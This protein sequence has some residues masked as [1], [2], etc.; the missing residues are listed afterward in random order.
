M[1]AQ[2]PIGLW[3]PALA[4]RSMPSGMPLTGSFEP[5]AATLPEDA[6][7]RFVTP[8]TI[9]FDLLAAFAEIGEAQRTVLVRFVASLEQHE[10]TGRGVELSGA[11]VRDSLEHLRHDLRLSAGALASLIG[12]S[13]RRYYEFRAGDEPPAARLAEVRDRVEVIRSLAARDLATATELCRRRTTVIAGLL[14][15]GR[16]AAVEELFQRTIRERARTLAPEERPDISTSEANVLLAVIEQPAFRKIL[17]ILRRF[18]PALD[19]K[20]SDRAA[21]ALRLEKS[22]RAVAEGE[23]VEDDWEFMLVMSAEAIDDLRGRADDVIRDEGFDQEMWT[24]FIAGESERAWAAFDYRPADT[25][26]AREAKKVAHAVEAADP[27][28]SDFGHFGVDLSL[29]DRRTR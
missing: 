14:A 3:E 4:R 29:Y 17:Q 28:L 11:V 27:W 1:T 2:T 19:A 6:P 12:I 26:E 13:K 16:F 18:A 23:P 20:T 22:I 25:L 8:S 5:R 24:A 10:V 21:A 7:I 15:A 9:S